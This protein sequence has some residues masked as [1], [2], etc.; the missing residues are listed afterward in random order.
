MSAV[1][2]GVQQEVPPLP[3]L[4]RPEIPSQNPLV[5][6]PPHA[7]YLDLACAGMIEGPGRN[8]KGMRL[9]AGSSAVAAG[10]TA[11]AR[12]SDGGATEQ[13]APR[14]IHTLHP[15]FFN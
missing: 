4:P 1:L 12:H 6:V 10:A 15:R 14:D 9:T 13:V 2:P 7:I 8:W 3:V 5:P 11:R